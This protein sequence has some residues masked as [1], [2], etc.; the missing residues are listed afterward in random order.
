[1]FVASLMAMFSIEAPDAPP[2]SP[3]GSVAGVWL[4][5]AVA[6]ALQVAP[7]NTDSRLLPV[8]VVVVAT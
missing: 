5:P 2:D 1:M 4:H 6:A 8:V 3:T 7:L